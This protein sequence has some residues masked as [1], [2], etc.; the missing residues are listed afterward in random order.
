MDFHVSVT[1]NFRVVEPKLKIIAEGPT[2]VLDGDQAI[3]S[4]TVQNPGSGRTTNVRVKAF[5]PEELQAIIKSTVYNLGSPNPGESR[6]V[7][8]LAKVM[9]LG[10]HK[11]TFVAIADCGLTAKDKHVTRVEGIAAILLEV[12]DVDDPVKVG[13]ETYYEI[14]ITNQGTEFAKNVTIS[15]TV[16]DGIAILGS[17]GPSD[18]KITGQTIT[19]K[20]LP[21]LAPR[22]DA[23]YP[24]KVRTSKPGDLRIEVEASADS[25]KMPVKE[26]ESTKVYQD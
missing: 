24:I 22:A 18:G 12:V 14:L 20:T 21:K 8:V 5:L 2:S 3:F 23:I 16:P 10:N 13:A 1:A 19:F 17:K 6:S 26:L 15:A 4:I 7:R 25:L 9:K 11:V